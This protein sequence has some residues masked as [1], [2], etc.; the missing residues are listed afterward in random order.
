MIGR[1]LDLL[2]GREAPALANGADELEQAVAAL[3]IEAARMDDDFDAAE[4][5]TIERVLATRFALGPAAVA[6]LVE[7]AE[8][9]VR[10][11][12]QLFPFT[13]QICR[14]MSPD[15]RIQIIEM[16]WK[17]AY[18]DGILDPHEDMLL[19]RIAGLIH[20]PDRDRAIAR[21]NAIE[22]LGGRKPS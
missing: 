20:V 1:M 8:A 15:E 16:L 18:A 6:D 3:L 17:V 12:T 5:A 13:Q 19:R 22:K 11:S 10:Q 2:T 14:R 9:A 21:Q 7:A 4:R